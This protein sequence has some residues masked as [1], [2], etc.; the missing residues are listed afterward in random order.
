[1]TDLSTVPTEISV[2]PRTLELNA[3][4]ASSTPEEVAAVID[5]ASAAA[6]ATAR[7]TP[8]ERARW[9]EAVADAV[10]LAADELAELADR[11]SGLGRARLDGEVARCA[12]Q[13]R[14]YAAVAQEGS[15]LDATIDHGGDGAPDVRRLR[16]PVGPVAVFGASNFPFAFGTLGHDTGSALAAGCPVVVKGHPAHPLTHARLAEVARA[17]LAEAGAP[18]GVLGSVTGFDAG[19]ALVMHPMI[20]TVAFTGSQR[21]GMALWSMANARA[22]VIPVYAEMGTVNP[23]VVTPAAAEDRSD[24][25]EGCVA[26]YTMGMGQFCTKPGLVLAPAGSR[27]GSEIVEALKAQ[28]PRGPMLTADIARSYVAGVDRLV[29]AGGTVIAS[30]PE[31]GL[32]AGVSACVVQAAAQL[33]VPGSALLEEC[34]GPVVVLVEYTGVD[35]LRRSLSA[36]SGCLVG[37]VF[38]AGP[39][40]PVAPAAVDAVARIAGRVAVDAWPTGVATTWAQHH[41]GPW[42]STSN[43]AATSVGSAALSRFTRSVAYQGAPAE[44]LPRPLR[45]R[46]EWRVPRRIDGRIRLPRRS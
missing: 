28:S 22:D 33:L 16:V 34:F 41:G 20:R 9:L 23:V 36:L 26:S 29:A 17:A 5:L 38:T 11:E 44:L 19:P 43:P 18:E 10:L 30:V 24:L 14:F 45:D 25:A 40:D 31:P 12:D 35:D 27:I 13:L 1:M 37:S 8:P 39:G 3:V 42:P 15:W 2:D 6:G 4:L 32:G 7:A 46:N 21:G